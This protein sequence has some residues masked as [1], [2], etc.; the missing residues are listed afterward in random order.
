MKNISI[1][2]FALFLLP[3]ASEAQQN[4][5]FQI[6][7]SGSVD[8][9]VPHE[10]WNPVLQTIEMPK[11]GGEEEESEIKPIKDS[12][13]RRYPKRDLSSARIG[14]Q[15]SSAT[16]PFLN[17][18]F[19][20]NGFNNST[21]TDNEI[22]ISNGGKI[23]SVQNSNIF[24][25]DIV[26]A[27]TTGPTT[28]LTSFFSTLAN[29]QS[30]YDPKVIYDPVD[31][32]FILLCLAGFTD[33]TSSILVGF[34]QTNDPNGSWNLYTLPGNPLNDTLWSDYPMVSLT[35]HDVFIT[36]NLLHNNQPWQ[37][38][39][40]QSVIWQM[41]KQDG[42]TGATM[43]SQLHTNVA[44]NG[45]NVRNL[46]PVKGGS[47]LYGPDAYFVSDRNL[48]AM[49]DTFFLIHITDTINAPTQQTNVSAL[50]SNIA[51]FAPADADQPTTV[52]NL[53][54]NDARV[55]G[56]FIEN[57][58]IQFVNN[59]M[60]TVSGHAS[61]FHGVISNVST[62][63]TLAGNLIADPALEFGY[64]NLAY[65]GNGATDNTSIISF[66]M[67]NATVKPGVSALLW[68][69]TSY[70]SLTTVKAGLGYINVLNGLERWGDYTGTQRRYNNPGEVWVNGMY[71]LTNHQHATWIAELGLNS[72][73]GIATPQ[74]LVETSIAPNPFAE[75]IEIK[76]SIDEEAFLRFTITDMQGRLVKTLLED[77]VNAG[78]SRFSFNTG[79]LAKGNYLLTIRSG[80]EI[81]TT[82]KIIRQ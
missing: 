39:W 1:L 77:R 15:T 58:M 7:K 73:V 80:N 10:D 48:D 40:V 16:A 37:T 21:P 8:L 18:N 66:L 19:A 54:T 62:T 63:P 9:S 2:C 5:I 45:R 28:S 55:L 26:T 75:T 47:T 20:G 32:R 29:T 74:P 14:E 36:V 4:R 23:V 57:N 27:A 71:G 33:S 24:R 65:A 70:S 22:A 13:M 11:P 49:N 64:P 44:H 69:G 51:Y 67:S 43:T 12:L 76:F 35:Q 81:I 78:T 6:P 50:V 79:A 25:Y 41:D 56:A 34:S 46:C 72:N 60:D 53:A 17:R 59:T 30:K 31:D 3:Q 42:Y 38:G 52:D 61:V 82:K 68:D